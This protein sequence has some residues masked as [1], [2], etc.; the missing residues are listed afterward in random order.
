VKLLWKYLKNYKKLVFLALALA[1]V[2]QVFSLFDPLLI[3]K[4]I[5]RCVKQIPG[6]E[7]NGC[8]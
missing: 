6:F 3:G 5:D 2:N 7:K 4:L 8:I 1:T